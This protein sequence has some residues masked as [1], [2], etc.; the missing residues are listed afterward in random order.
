M[1]IFILF[2]SLF[3]DHGLRSQS[4]GKTKSHHLSQNK[5]EAGD[6]TIPLLVSLG[7]ASLLFL[8]L[9]LLNKLY[10]HR[11]KEHLHEFKNQW[12]QLEKKYKK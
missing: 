5:R 1:E 12:E 8:G 4:L 6:I 10:H 11:T 2:K 3:I 7:T 9:F